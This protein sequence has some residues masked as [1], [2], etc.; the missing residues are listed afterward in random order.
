M[1]IEV[2]AKDR[3]SLF[4]E[5]KS[6]APGLSEK[7]INSMIDELLDTRKRYT[8]QKR[9]FL[10]E[11]MRYRAAGEWQKF[12]DRAL[13]VYEVM[14]EAFKHFD[15]VPDSMKYDFAISAYIHHGD[16]IPAVRR[17][18]RSC[19]RYGAPKLPA[20]LRDKE[21][22]TVYRAGEEPRGKAAYRLSWTTDRR[23]AEFFLNEYVHRHANYLYQAQIKTADIIAYV[24]DREEREVLQ[25]RKVFDIQ[26]ITDRIGE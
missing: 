17:A 13:T 9:R 26:D 19:R 16:S 23:I 5:V 15:E 4:D 10:P 14:P 21:Q 6:K 20:D 11:L 8:A 2:S 1:V 3:K 25:Y 22:I 18:V 7:A 24:D 12:I